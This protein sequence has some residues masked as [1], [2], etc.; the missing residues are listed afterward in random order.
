MF[1]G[2][3]VLGLGFL[4]QPNLS[5]QPQLSLLGLDLAVKV[6]AG[7]L[8]VLIL[9]HQNLNYNNKM[10]VRKL[11]PF[12]FLTGM[13]VLVLSGLAMATASAHSSDNGSAQSR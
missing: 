8:G 2:Q 11:I 4:P 10:L 5:L 3:L 9:R 6:K 7:E 12:K 1:F 13:V